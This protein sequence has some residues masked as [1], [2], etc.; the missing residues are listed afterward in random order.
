MNSCECSIV[1]GYWESVARARFA[2]GKGGFAWTWVAWGG[3]NW[4]NDNDKDKGNKKTKKIETQLFNL[5]GD[6]TLWCT[7]GCNIV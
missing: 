6:Y 1:S 2:S 3:L 7:L 4:N 5:V